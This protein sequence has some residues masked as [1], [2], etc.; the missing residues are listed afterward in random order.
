MPASQTC[1][2]IIISIIII[3]IIIYYTTTNLYIIHIVISVFITIA[4]AKGVTEA[5]KHLDTHNIQKK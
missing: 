1:I 2:F 5:K 4:V 3:Y